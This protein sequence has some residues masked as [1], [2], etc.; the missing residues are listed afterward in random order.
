LT[1][2]VENGQKIRA[3]KFTGMGDG[4][5][6]LAYFKAV[7]DGFTREEVQAAAIAARKQAKRS[8]GQWVPN[9]TM[10]HTYQVVSANDKGVIFADKTTMPWIQT[11]KLTGRLRIEAG[12]KDTLL[13]KMRRI[14]VGAN[15]TRPQIATVGKAIAA[16]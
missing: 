2:L 5:Y 3:S 14:Y 10:E 13:D 8:G 9:S 1:V 11:A 12:R 15:G 7:A 6:N 16:L 4:A